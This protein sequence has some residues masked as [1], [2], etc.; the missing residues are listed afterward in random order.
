MCPYTPRN[1]L[2]NR[3]KVSRQKKNLEDGMMC[4]YN[5]RNAYYHPPAPNKPSKTKDGPG[6]DTGPGEVK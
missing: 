6:T 2:P 1:D 4:P 3:D 5:S